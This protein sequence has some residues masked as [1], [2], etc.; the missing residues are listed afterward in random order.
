[1]EMMGK[2]SLL[3]AGAG[4]I[5]IANSC[6]AAENVL[7]DSKADL[8]VSIYNQNLALIKDR[9][10]VSLQKGEN[11]IAFEGVATQIKPETAIL[12]ADGI[13]VLEQN[14][15][16]DLMNAANI[17]DK[18]VGQKVKTVM[19]NPVTGENMFNSA[20]IISAA[21]GTP[22]LEFDYGIEANFPGR[23]VFENMPKSLRSKPT[24]VAK[25]E[26]AESADKNIALAYLTNGIGWKTNYVAKVTEN[27]K[28][29]LTGWVTINNQSGI[30]Y[31]NAEVQLIAG[32][33][34]Q[35]AANAV[36]VPRMR[37]MAKA[38]VAEYAMDSVT[39]AGSA[40]AISGYHLYTLPLK[41]DIKDNQTKQISLL[42]KTGVLFKKQAE[43]KSSLY[44]N[45]S[46]NAE[47]K[48]RHPEMIYVLN[49]TEESNLGV[50]LPA[51]VVRFYENDAGG[52]M[53]FIG[54]NSI[55]HVAKGEEMKLLLG[56]F[57]N[58][59]VNG[60]VISVNKVGETDEKTDNSNCYMQNTVY[61]YKV[62]VTFTNGGTAPQEVVFQQSLPKDARIMAENH[63]GTEKYAG[64]YEWKVNLSEDSS[65]ELTFTVRAI[66]KKRTCR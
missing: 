13:K 57:F 63:K 25:I 61:D 16:Y 42:E 17:I 53:Q 10:P 51:G 4:I 49:N 45:P 62:A 34:N 54:E 41:T 1:M 11:E 23:L 58:I 60:K 27:G 21:Y 52:N 64:L 46:G 30:D 18:S 36:P 9:R 7:S 35:V 32:D 37:L 65:K 20:T 28:L 39:S 24:L 14:Y 2:L 12:Y 44:F 56:S 6:Q 47:F 5:G 40:E 29:D 43:L 15:D 66:D 38:A 33:V 48:Q 8:Q 22:V 31:K 55:S 59:F 26:S 3:L 19:S 50:P